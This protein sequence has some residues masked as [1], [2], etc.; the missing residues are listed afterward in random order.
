M[1]RGETIGVSALQDGFVELCFDRAGDPVNRFD[2]RTVAELGEAVAVIAAAPGVRGVLATSAKDVFIVGADIPELREKLKWPHAEL[3]ADVRAGNEI[4]VLLED[5]PFPTVAAIDGYALGGGFEFALA[6]ALRVMSYR[7]RVGLPEVNLGVFPG[8]G[9]TVRLARVAGAETAVRWIADGRQRAHEAALADRAV[10][11]ACPSDALRATAL[12]LLCRAADGRVDWRAA[13]Q[14]KRDAVPLA[15]ASRAAL[16]GLRHTVA[17]ASAPHQPA[18]LAALD[19][20]ER[21]ASL[22]R[23]AA[24]AMESDAFGRIAHTQAAV[25]LMQVFVSEHRVKRLA[26]RRAKAAGPVR[27]AVVLGAGALAGAIALAGARH[28]ISVG[29]GG[30]A[31]GAI[32]RALTG[33]HRQLEVQVEAGRLTRADSQAVLRRMNVQQGDADLA[34]ADLVVDATG[35]RLDAKRLAA[36]EPRL[37]AAATVAS[38]A[39]GGVRIDDI[40]GALQ[41]PQRLVGMHFVGAAPPV[42]EVVRGTATCDEAVAT[43]LAYAAAM[44]KT[45]IVVRDGPGLLVDRLLAAYTGA[46]LRLLAEGAD[47]L[48]VDRAMEAFGWAMGPTCLLDVIGID[49][50]VHLGNV[51]ALAYPQRMPAIEPNALKLL[52]AAGRLGQKSGSGFH[53]YERGAGGNL[54]RQVAP[55]TAALLAALQPAGPTQFSD[56]QVADRLMLPLVV[57]AAHALE[58][59]V[60]STPDE[61]DIALL[62]AGC[63]AYTGGPLKYADWLGLAEVVRRCDALRSCGPMYEPTPRMRQLAAAGATFHS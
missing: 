9:G 32:D 48:A 11:A 49:T 26:K 42:V 52:M 35:E 25:S 43:A 31:L 46:A 27:E 22:E 39:C 33:A 55:E 6:C 29:L 44:K 58:E 21:A 51:L 4:F 5:F 59:G 56:E 38:S 57:E 3:V 30:A 12:D 63:P 28:G 50:S 13:Q 10:D 45:A 14:R 17:A 8:F 20:I 23:E 62:G 15:A 61:L 41:R 7:A 18:A 40:A 24:L 47:Y 60:V 54:V 2:S 36:L 1:Y 37:S 53:R 16:G 34:R 19:L